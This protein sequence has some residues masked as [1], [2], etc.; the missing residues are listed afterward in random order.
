[1]GRRLGGNPATGAY[2]NDG[3]FPSSHSS[4]TGEVPLEGAMI[5]GKNTRELMDKTWGP[6]R[7]SVPVFVP[8]SDKAKAKNGGGQ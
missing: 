2:E 4:Y 1:M 7:Y 5:G 6:G 8:P 3:S